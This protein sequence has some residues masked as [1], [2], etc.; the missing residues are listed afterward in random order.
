[1]YILFIH[2]V[3]YIFCNL[4]IKYTYEV[5]FLFIIQLKKKYARRSSRMRS[6]NADIMPTSWLKTSKLHVLK[7]VRGTISLTLYR[8]E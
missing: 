2:F 5:T 7:F 8:V 6:K 4:I 3:T 1:M